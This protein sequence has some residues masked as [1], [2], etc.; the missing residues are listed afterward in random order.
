MS[1]SP[2]DFEKRAEETAAACR[3]WVAVIAQALVDCAPSLLKA[4]LHSAFEAIEWLRT[5]GSG[6]LLLLGMR[7]AAELA[8]R[9]GSDPDARER[10]MAELHM[11]RRRDRAPEPRETIVYRPRRDPNRRST[12][13]APFSPK[14]SPHR[15]PQ[16]PS[17]IAALL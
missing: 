16:P 15:T 17:P 14:A 11:V 1:T 7:D 13:N 12:F 8:R 3:L 2:E 10:L 9:V 6:I 5:T 4:R